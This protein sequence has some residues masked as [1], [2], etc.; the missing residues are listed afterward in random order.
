[1]AQQKVIHWHETEVVITGY[2]K[3][4]S[5]WLVAVE[6]DDHPRPGGVMELGIGPR[7][8]MVSM[9]NSN[10]LA[11]MDN[12]KDQTYHA[13]SKIASIQKKMLNAVDH[14][15]NIQGSFH[16]QFQNNGQNEMVE[17]Q[18]DE[19]KTPG[20]HVKVT[21]ANGNETKS[22]G[23]E[24]LIMSHGIEKFS[25]SNVAPRKEVKRPRHFSNENSQ[26]VF[27]QQQLKK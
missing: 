5:G 17:F 14:Y 19:G 6:V 3:K 2:R 23:K 9:R 18:V 21:K 8:D 4:E 25:K 26:P 10:A 7:A 13:N 27:V 22:N 15:Q 24:Y 20:S 12:L 11:N 16:I 1:M